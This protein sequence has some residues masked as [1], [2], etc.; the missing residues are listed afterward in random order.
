MTSINLD[1]NANAGNAATTKSALH[2]LPGTG[3]TVEGIL[4]MSTA[5]T[6]KE[7]TAQDRAELEAEFAA[8]DA[9]KSIPMG[10]R[11]AGVLTEAMSEPRFVQQWLDDSDKSFRPFAAAVLDM[12]NT[13]RMTAQS[14]RAVF[15]DLCVR[16]RL[17]VLADIVGKPVP[18][19]VL[20]LMG[21]TS[22]K[23][24]SHRDWPA[25]MSVAMGSD[26]TKLG[27]VDRITP[28]L[29]RQ[30]ELI[31][32]VLR[33]PALYQVVSQLKVTVERWNQ[34]RGFLIAAPQRG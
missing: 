18:P 12:C 31:P 5:I 6:G 16:K 15:Q 26:N 7:P 8:E 10:H 28:T 24:F 14:R 27:H 9:E 19:K 33:T 20:K 2:L 25:F 11:L 32:G 30:F 4:K 22:W 3:I 34:L 1:G 21:R 17:A 29:V 13:K 23:E